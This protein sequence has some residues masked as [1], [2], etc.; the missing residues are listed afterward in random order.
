MTD[1]ITPKRG[2]GR[3]RK[4]ATLSSD[5]PATAPK[6]REPKAV[7]TE[8]VAKRKPGRPAKATTTSE[9]SATTEPKKR[10]R[11]PKTQEETTP[12]TNVIETAAAKIVEV[13]QGGIEVLR[14]TAA[15]LGG[16]GTKKLT[17][18]LKAAEEAEKKAD[19]ARKKADKA[20][21]KQAG[22]LRKATTAKMQNS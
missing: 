15:K 21:N 16:K 13:V 6:K 9:T 18:A 2:P 5:T 4:D 11:K 12:A 14:D 7:T 19:K 1:E 8:T 17:K 20:V 3:P 22:K 10:G